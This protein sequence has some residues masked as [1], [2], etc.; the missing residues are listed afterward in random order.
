[1]R[2]TVLCF[3]SAQDAAG[4]P[5]LSLEINEGSTVGDAVTTLVAGHPGLRP[6]IPRLRFAVDTEFVGESAALHNGCTLALLPPM[7]GG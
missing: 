4:C 5:E 1:M 3:A 7:S 6:L 2:V